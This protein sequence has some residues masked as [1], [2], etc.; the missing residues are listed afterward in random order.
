[1]YNE[2]SRIQLPNLSDIKTKLY[3][4]IRTK[5]SKPLNTFPNHLLLLD[6][7]K[8]L[9]TSRFKKGSFIE[10]NEKLLFQINY[11]L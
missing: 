4:Y 2:L 10:E 11:K 7:R 6:A 8:P 5:G 9:Y 3:V 1:M